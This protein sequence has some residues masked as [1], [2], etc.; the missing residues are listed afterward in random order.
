MTELHNS[1]D[2]R[3]MIAEVNAVYDPA[4]VV[5][6]GIEAFIDNG[7]ERGTKVWGNVILAGVDRVAID[8][9]GLAILRD[10]GCSGVAA[11]GPIFA[12]EQIAQAVELGLGVDGVDK[13][14]FVTDDPQSTAY[15]AQVRELML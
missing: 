3:L 4:L 9:T 15:A 12:Q 2:Q 8:A 13:I 5:L 10:L 1:P 7:P 14:E 11:K 6:D